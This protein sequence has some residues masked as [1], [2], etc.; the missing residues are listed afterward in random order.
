M[1]RKVLKSDLEL[2]YFFQVL[3]ETTSAMNKN[4]TQ[5][6]FLIKAF[7]HV[8]KAWAS[9]DACDIDKSNSIDANELKFLLYCAEG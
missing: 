2:D 7:D 4:I 9:F 8:V 5:G 3:I 6:Y 1:K